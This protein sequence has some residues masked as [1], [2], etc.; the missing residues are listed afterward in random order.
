MAEMAEKCF[1]APP[2][3]QDGRLD[4]CVGTDGRDALGVALVTVIFLGAERNGS[5][6]I[7]DAAHSVSEDNVGHR[8]NLLPV[9]FSAGSSFKVTRETEALNFIWFQ[10]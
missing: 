10:S 6:G 7:F 3:V 5:W 8:E 4:A 1:I 9:F 2:G